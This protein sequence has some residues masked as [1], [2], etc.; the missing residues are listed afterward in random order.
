MKLH[1][2]L[3]AMV[4]IASSA[5]S[6]EPTTVTIDGSV[7]DKDNQAI[8]G[9]LVRAY[10]DGVPIRAIDKKPVRTDKNGRYKFVIE[11][12]APLTTFTYFH[13]D[14]HMGAVSLLAARQ[15]TKEKQLVRQHINKVLFRKTDKLSTANLAQVLA[16]YNSYFA[17][18]DRSVSTASTYSKPVADLSRISFNP[19]YA[20]L[21]S[22]ALSRSLSNLKQTSQSQL[23]LRHIQ[24]TRKS[25]AIAYES[26]LGQIIVANKDGVE[27]LDPLTGKSTFQQKTRLRPGKYLFATSP[28]GRHFAVANT[29]TAK[30]HIFSVSQQ[31]N[32]VV[33]VGSGSLPEKNFSVVSISISSRN[34]SV[35]ALT[36]KHLYISR[37]TDSKVIHRKVVNEK[38]SDAVGTR[39]K[40]IEYMHDGRMLA[41][42]DSMVA[43]F[44]GT[45]M[46]SKMSLPDEKGTDRITCIS[47]TFK[48]SR[49]LYDFLVGTQ[50]GSLYVGSTWD[51]KISPHFGAL[52]SG[53]IYYIPPRVDV[54]RSTFPIVGT[55][56]VS[57]VGNRLKNLQTKVSGVNSSLSR[58]RAVALHDNGKSMVLIAAGGAFVYRYPKST[59]E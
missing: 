20:D 6:A 11:S 54:S 57:I 34:A 46:V 51:K 40:R 37:L 2:S 30:S 21:R 22:V 24:S 52:Y 56:G 7:V 8:P 33:F 19:D 58:I 55:K 14:W 53:A 49:K 59:K 35:A 42:A 28:S 10:R 44:S 27:L 3:F 26:R 41:A 18:D 9:V 50:R 13:N 31:K 1:I 36:R 23:A 29:A 48:R 45:R 39:L 15:I 17:T 25:Y 47:V 43:L 5:Y 12:G 16:D 32:K 4:T 38:S